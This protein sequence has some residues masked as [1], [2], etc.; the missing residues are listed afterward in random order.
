MRVLLDYIFQC[1]SE[2]STTNTPI[3]VPRLHIRKTSQGTFTSSA[4]V[5]SWRV[6]TSQQPVTSLIQC[7]VHSPVTDQQ[8]L[9]AKEYVQVDED[10]MRQK[11]PE[12]RPGLLLTPCRLFVTK[13]EINQKAVLSK[14][15]DRSLSSTKFWKWFFPKANTT[16]YKMAKRRITVFRTGLFKEYATL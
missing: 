13:S 10:W 6:E 3:H 11:P 14:K 12:A 7:E 5:N 15:D 8:I 9:S 4:I 2:S 1:S 16:T